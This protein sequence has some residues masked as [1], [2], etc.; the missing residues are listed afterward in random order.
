MVGTRLLAQAVDRG[1][2]TVLNAEA[3]RFLPLAHRKW[4][5]FPVQVRVHTVYR[6]DATVAFA[7]PGRGV[8]IDQSKM[9]AEND[10]AVDG[11]AHG[12]ISGIRLSPTGNVNLIAP[13]P[14]P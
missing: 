13:T 2:S 10:G 12:P 8:C 7:V 5:D 1:A 9:A 14:T 4:F 11:D 6:Y 3:R